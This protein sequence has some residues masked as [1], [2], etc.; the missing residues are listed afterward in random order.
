MALRQTVLDVVR[1]TPT[2]AGSCSPAPAASGSATWGARWL[3]GLTTTAGLE[4][5]R[6][7]SIYGAASNTS[8][9]SERI[10]RSTRSTA[11]RR[12]PRPRPPN[13]PTGRLVMRTRGSPPSVRRSTVLWG[14]CGTWR[15]ASPGRPSGPGGHE[16]PGVALDEGGG[17]SRV[18]GR[19]RPPD[20]RRPENVPYV[21]LRALRAD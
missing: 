16:G 4:G 21:S 19:A 10:G 2:A 18:F 15:L 5:R 8:T 11:G 20:R 12:R 3:K 13:G 1:R 17:T 6:Q 7:G 14:R 9:C